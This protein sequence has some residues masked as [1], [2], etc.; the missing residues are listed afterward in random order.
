MKIINFDVK[1][2]LKQRQ[3]F[4]C[5]KVKIVISLRLSEKIDKDMVLKLRPFLMKKRADRISC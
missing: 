3:N 5:V 2:T 1:V 4:D